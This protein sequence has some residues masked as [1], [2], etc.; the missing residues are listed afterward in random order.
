MKEKKLILTILTST[1]GLVVILHSTNVYALMARVV[2]N[3]VNLAI[4][5]I[6]KIAPVIFIIIYFIIGIIYYMKSKKS[7]KEK[8]KRLVIWLIIILIISI[9]L[10]FCADIVYKAGASYSS[11]PRNLFK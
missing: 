8:I 4:S 2:Y 6:M 10:Y 3:P 5:I 7:K 9:A 11:S 1:I